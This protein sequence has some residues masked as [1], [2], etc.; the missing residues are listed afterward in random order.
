MGEQ[1]KKTTSTGHK[2]LSII[3]LVLCVVFAFFLIC[4]IT[5]I[6]KGTLYPERP[7]SVLSVTPLVVMSGS[8]SGDAP[9]HI[10]VG[11]LIFVGRAKAEE[12]KVGD[13]IAFMEEEG[14][15]TVIT[16]RITAV[17]KAEDGGIQWQT[18]GDAN[19]SGDTDP[20]HQDNLVGIYLF[21]I[22][23]V[24]DFALFLQEP[25]G[26]VLFIGVPLLAFIIYDIIRRQKYANKENKRTAELE[27][28][29]ERLRSLQG[30]EADTPTVEKAEASAEE[31][32]DSEKKES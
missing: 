31:K 23:K 18:K 5:I 25:L 22:A 12:L 11:D 6:V 32:A 27:A 16:H 15:T 13:V 10:E 1:T 4:N 29:I 21:R 19:P 28:E 14:S 26:M 8:M 3:G 9:D 17:E 2:V 24:G 30:T 20:V 7:P